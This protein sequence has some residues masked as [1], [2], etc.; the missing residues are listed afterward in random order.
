[1]SSRDPAASSIPVPPNAKLTPGETAR[2]SR[3]LIESLRK[4]ASAQGHSLLAH[5]LELAAI[6]AKAI[7][8]EHYAQETRLPE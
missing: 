3:D 2:Y 5:L 1:M 7:A 6:E 4:I 8:D